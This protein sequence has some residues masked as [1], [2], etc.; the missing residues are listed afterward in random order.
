MK[1]KRS[2]YWGHIAIMTCGITMM[3]MDDKHRFVFILGLFIYA[4]EIVS[5]R[6]EERDERNQEKEKP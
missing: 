3:H 4:N 2:R 5:I 6:L 1:S